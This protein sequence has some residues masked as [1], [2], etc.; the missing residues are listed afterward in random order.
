MIRRVRIETDG[1]VEL[2]AS[3]W[4]TSAECHLVSLSL[5]GM[6]AALQG[7]PGDPPSDGLC[8]VIQGA[9]DLSTRFAGYGAALVQ[10][11]LSELRAL[12]AHVHESRADRASCE[13]CALRLHAEC[14]TALELPAPRGRGVDG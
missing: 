10:A 3:T 8:K 11:E 12:P 5:R 7:K 2:R 9:V 1:P 13:L 14:L 6:A 4:V